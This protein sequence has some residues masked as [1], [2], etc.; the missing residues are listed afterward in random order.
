[1]VDGVTLRTDAPP[2]GQSQPSFT[3]VQRWRA[4]VGSHALGVRAYNAAG[5]ASDP[6]I[7]AITVAQSSAGIVP[8]TAIQL[9]TAATTLAPPTAT[10]TAT[11]S[12][13]AT[14]TPPQPTATT[15]ATA[16]PS[17]TATAT[18]P[19]PTATATFTP[20]PNPKDSLLA[21]LFAVLGKIKTYR[22]EIPEESRV[23]EYVLPDRVRQ[24]E[25]DS[26]IKIGPTYYQFV[27][28]RWSAQNVGIVPYMD[29]ANLL[30]FR[31]QVTQS[32]QVALLGAGT[33]DGI[34]CNGYAVTFTVYQV[35]PPNTPQPIQSS[36]IVKVWFTVRDGLPAL[37]EYGPPIVASVY[38]FDYNASIEI[39]PP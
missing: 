27:R 3:L 6:A 36:Q 39:N 15:T 1:M 22:V 18:L 29:R 25:P 7:I 17:S 30:R 19:Q 28:G 26:I 12:S 38:F 31:D 10:A 37:I 16:T 8:T 35:P 9:P 23:M 2:S 34:P 11:P 21:A 32:T 20:T 13:T 24:L 4:T 5:T 33:V 14:T